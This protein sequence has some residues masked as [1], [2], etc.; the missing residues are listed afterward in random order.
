MGDRLEQS[1]AAMHAAKE[2]ALEA[3]AEPWQPRPIYCLDVAYNKGHYGVLEIGS[4]NSAGLDHCDLL[5]VIQAMN[6]IAVR[7]FR[8]R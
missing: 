2:F 7:D 3:A 5:R 8:H 6:E 4:I 1:S